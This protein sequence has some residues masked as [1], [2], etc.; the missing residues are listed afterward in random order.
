MPTPEVAE[1]ERRRL[2]ARV[3]SA[4]LAE[5]ADSD[6][7]VLSRWRSGS[8]RPS[9]VTLQAYQRAMNELVA[10]RVAALQTFQPYP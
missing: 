5:R 6:E 8:S 9:A 1:L 7:A 4:E 3:T 10:E 2:A